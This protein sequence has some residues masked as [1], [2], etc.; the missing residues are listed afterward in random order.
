MFY[1]DNVQ[2]RVFPLLFSCVSTFV[3]VCFHF[4]FRV[5][6]LL[7]SC[8]STFVFVCF[9]FC[10]RVFP[11]LFS[12]FGWCTCGMLLCI[13]SWS[14]LHVCQKKP[15]R[16]SHNWSH[17]TPIGFSLFTALLASFSKSHLTSLCIFFQRLF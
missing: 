1:P 9:H 12:T 10:F 14:L 16:A 17:C 6:P 15:N 8:V 4:C 11:L 7:F 2:L 3:F 13:E 5:F